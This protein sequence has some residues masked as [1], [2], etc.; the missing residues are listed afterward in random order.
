MQSRKSTYS[1]L[2]WKLRR[3][4]RSLVVFEL[5]AHFQSVQKIT[6]SQEEL[7]II[8]PFTIK[9]NHTT[10]VLHFKAK[11]IIPLQ[12]H[13]NVFRQNNRR[14]VREIELNVNN[15]QINDHR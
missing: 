2:K 4:K 6:L 14:D 5:T 15:D 1:Y 3:Q 7:M 10:P 12:S 11:E 8:K 9:L 13:A